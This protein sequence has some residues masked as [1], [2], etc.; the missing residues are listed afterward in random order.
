MVWVSVCGMCMFR[1][2][3]LCN[4]VMV[5]CWGL[6]GSHATSDL[7]SCFWTCCWCAVWNFFGFFK[8]RFVMSASDVL[9][10]CVVVFPLEFCCRN[11][12]RIIEIKLWMFVS[13]SYWWISRC[14]VVFFV[15]C[16]CHVRLWVCLHKSFAREPWLKGSPR[17]CTFSG[18]PRPNQ[19]HQHISFDKLT[20]GYRKRLSGLR[21]GS[22]NVTDMPENSADHFLFRGPGRE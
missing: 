19:N 16:L 10:S 12:F 3:W 2:Q 6:S 17:A 7:K 15:V 4:V 21:A 18:T 22:Q 9:G 8:F 11:C 5:W 20:D 1:A 14:S 13:T